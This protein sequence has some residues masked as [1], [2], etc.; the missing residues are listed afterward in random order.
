MYAILSLCLKIG[1]NFVCVCVLRIFL[2][3]E[4]VENREFFSREG[5][6]R[7]R[8]NYFSLYA[9]ALEIFM[10]LYNVNTILEYKKYVS[11]FHSNYWQVFISRMLLCHR[12]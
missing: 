5:G 2:E 4:R 12:E 1:C 7:W 3:K 9:L 6:Q 10:R 8:E 11:Y